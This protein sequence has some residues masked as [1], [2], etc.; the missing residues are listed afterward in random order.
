MAIQIPSIKRVDPV[1][2]QSIGRDQTQAPSAEPY[3]KN[4]NTVS[5]VFDKGAD[6]AFKYEKQAQDNQL[7]DLTNKYKASLYGTGDEKE[8]WTVSRFQKA[9]KDGQDFTPAFAG[10]QEYKQ[11]LRD[12][13]M[14][15]ASGGV[16]ERLKTE[17]ADVDF[18]ADRTVNVEFY[19][20]NN[21]R[22]DK[23][24]SA[25]IDLI[26]Q[27][28]IP[29]AVGAYNPKDPDTVKQLAMT[30]N[31]IADSSMAHGIKLGFK[32]GDPVLQSMMREDVGEAVVKSVNDA[33]SIKDTDKAT[34]IWMQFQEMVPNKKAEPIKAKIAEVV[35]NKEIDSWA[36]K[37]MG[38]SEEVGVAKIKKEAP[39]QLQK[40]I[41]EK[42]IK[43]KTRQSEQ[44]GRISENYKNV[45]AT[46][47]LKRRQN[48]NAPLTL[49]DLNTEYGSEINKMN[50]GD[51]QYIYN[52]VGARSKIGD[53]AA[54]R[55]VMDA[56]ERND[57]AVK[58]WTMDDLLKNT[59]NFSTKEYNAAVS[60]WEKRND[61]SADHANV[62]RILKSATQRYQVTVDRTPEY[63]PAQADKW[64]QYIRPWLTSEIEKLPKVMTQSQIEQES[65]R[66]KKEVYKKLSDIKAN[67]LKEQDIFQYQVQTRPAVQSRKLGVPGPQTPVI[68]QVDKIKAQ[69]QK[70]PGQ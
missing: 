24:H 32:E 3:I 59:A 49:N 41:E 57:P 43:L 14:A 46:D 63:F 27:V 25:E 18:Y 30:F 6:L 44:L 35:I 51:K 34:Q 64:D 7:R 56:F 2:Q 8:S 58:S 70:A 38:V 66:L 17:L 19:K 12:Q 36:N 1:Q 20:A 42:Y 15:T 39:E 52:L 10:Y 54:Y 60:A 48:G 68:N 67:K 16:A 26:K 55:N 53:Y 29:A 11:S 47:F 62:M 13:V 31:K 40:D 69:Y 28:D 22:T 9:P 4:L 23:I 5:S 61:W 21:V 50:V 33:L 37:Y 45:V 65:A